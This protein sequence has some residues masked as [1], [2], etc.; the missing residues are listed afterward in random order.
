VVPFLLVSIIFVLV[1]IQVVLVLLVIPRQ[2][3]V[4]AP[5]IFRVPVVL[6]SVLVH[7]PIWVLV[8]LHRVVL[9]KCVCVLDKVRLVSTHQLHAT[10]KT[11]P[12]QVVYCSTTVLVIP[13]HIF[14]PTVVLLLIATNN[15]WPCSVAKDVQVGT[16]TLYKCKDFHVVELRVT[17]LLHRS[18]HVLPSSRHTI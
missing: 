9:F 13:I 16:L 14:N 4:P 17:L 12:L 3:S 18:V 10:L 6:D 8:I 11:E 15:C 5:L 7:H 2:L 1:H